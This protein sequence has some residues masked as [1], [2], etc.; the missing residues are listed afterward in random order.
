MRFNSHG[1][2]IDATPSQLNPNIAATLYDVDVVGLPDGGYFVTYNDSGSNLYG[3]RVGA[4]N[5]P[6]GNEF[7]IGKATY[8][9]ANSNETVNVELLGNGDVL[10][11]WDSSNSIWGRIISFGSEETASVQSSDLIIGTAADDAFVGTDAAETF[12]VEDAQGMDTLS[13]ADEGDSILFDENI[14]VNDLWFQQDGNN[15]RV[16]IIGTDDGIIVEDW[17]DDTASAQVDQFELASGE[18]LDASNVQ[19]LVDAMASFT[20]PSESEAVSSESAYQPLETVIATQW[21]S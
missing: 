2:P 17:F 4:D 18:T 6:I 3:Y 1:E 9:G 7:F 19:G 20:L 21:E 10:V 8:S 5:Q 16:S 11:S 14:A 12:K 13:N 15:L